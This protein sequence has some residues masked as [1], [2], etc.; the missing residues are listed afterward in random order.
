MYD[1]VVDYHQGMHM[2]ALVILNMCQYRTEETSNTEDQTSK[3]YQY[4][5]V[6]AFFLMVQFMQGSNITWKQ[7]F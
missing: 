1:E 6:T 2:I 5:E 4:D 7:I 3:I